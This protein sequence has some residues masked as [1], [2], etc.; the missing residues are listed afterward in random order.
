MMN[1]GYVAMYLRLSDDDENLGG[2]KRESDS[3]LNQRRVLENYISNHDEL[4]QYPIKEFVDDGVSGVSFNRPGIQ[5]L[6]NEVK[7]KKVACIVVKDLSRF[8]RNYIEV[9]DYIEQIFPFLGVRFIA[10]SDNFDS[11]KSPA[12]L[13]IGFRNLMHDLYSRD[14]SKKIKSVKKLMQEKGAYSG[15]DVPYGYMRGSEKEDVYIPDPEAAQIVRKIFLYAAEGDTTLQIAGKL[16]QEGIPTPGVYKN[17]SVNANY[18]LKNGKSNLW[19]ASQ[20]GLIIRNEV[21]IGTFVGRKLST[22]RPWERK[23]NEESEYIKIEGHHEGLVTEEL[24]REA[25]K[26][27]RVRKK[28]EAYK[29]EENPSPLKGKVKCGCCGYSMSLKRA[30][31]KKYYYCRMGSGCGSY[32]KIGLEPLEKTVWNVLQKL[33]E[34]YHEEE[35]ECQSKKVQILSAVSKMKEKKK[36]LEIQA[37]HCK[38]SRLDLY[39]QWKEGKIVKEEYAIKKDELARREA[40]NKQELELLDQQ[41]TETV[42]VQNSLEEKMGMAVMLDAEGLTKDL[43]DELIERIDVYEEDRVEIKWKFNVQL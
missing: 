6:L 17:R 29:K 11:F 26:A 42:L 27:I 12:G 8:G 5:S 15:G 25:Q 33:A 31:K 39:Y 38:S 37:E 43:V 16:N 18:E 22:A 20:V 3:I 1:D 30:V 28:R 2:E 4:A 32:L 10:V 24:F 9:G 13:D 34:A 23:K 19:A 7:K 36:I 41:M 35:E 21:Y 14:L 40:E